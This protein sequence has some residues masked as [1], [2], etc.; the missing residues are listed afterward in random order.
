[1]DCFDP[2]SIG[3]R[4]R[5]ESGS[6][7]GS[8]RTLESAGVRPA[9]LPERVAYH[10]LVEEMIDLIVSRGFTTL[11]NLRDS[12][13]RGNLKARDL[14]GPAEFFRGDRVLQTDRKLA[15]VLD[16]VHRRGEIYLRWLQRFSAVAFGTRFGRFLTRYLALPF[17]GAF[18]LLKALE[19]I[20]ELTIARLTGNHVELVNSTSIFLLGTVAL[21]LI[22]FIQ[23]RR[24]FF[25][26]IS[27]IGRL[28]PNRVA[29]LTR[30]SAQSS[31]AAMVDR[32][33]ACQSG[34]AVY[35]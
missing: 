29:G 12:V 15:V 10:K 4:L 27:A 7:R 35:D 25:A 24:A 6:S 11:G 31:T 17:G 28:A 22:N 2:P 5:F 1:M 8:C 32:E 23:L 30:T 33:C 21:G 26:S 14:S 19:E 18:V 16:G 20:N 13:S 9:N 34:L 3:P